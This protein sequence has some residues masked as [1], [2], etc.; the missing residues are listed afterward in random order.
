MNYRKLLIAT[1][2]LVLFACTQKHNSN[3]S[4]PQQSK[5]FIELQKKKAEKQKE[6]EKLKKE[7]EKLKSKKDSLKAAKDSI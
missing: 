7:I 1:V 6:V 4:A 3:N 5:E 2:F